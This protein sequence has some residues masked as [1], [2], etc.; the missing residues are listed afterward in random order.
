MC[1]P[2]IFLWIAHASTIACVLSFLSGTSRYF[3]LRISKGPVWSFLRHCQLHSFSRW[4]ALHGSFGD[5]TL[6][7]HKAHVR[8][9]IKLL[10]PVNIYTYEFKTF[11]VLFVKK[12]SRKHGKYLVW[13]NIC[14][15]KNHYHSFR[16][17][18]HSAT[19]A[20]LMSHTRSTKVKLWCQQ[21]FVHEQ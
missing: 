5:N 1:G 8:I 15:K 19:T 16:Q 17:L 21:L 20:T 6:H 9:C 11:C 2:L 10:H 4:L 13:A 7:L 3:P 18:I 12:D 14:S